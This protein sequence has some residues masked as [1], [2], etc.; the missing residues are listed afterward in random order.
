MD[1]YST[2]CAH[3][4]ERYGTLFFDLLKRDLCWHDFEVVWSDD[5]GVTTIGR[6]FTFHHF[7]TEVRGVLKESVIEQLNER[8]AGNRPRGSGIAGCID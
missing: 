4:E 3:L 2:V 8:R 6:E 1:R 7:K 5:G